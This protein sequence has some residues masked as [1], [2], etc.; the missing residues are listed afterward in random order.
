[1]LII[2]QIRYK[3]RS[4]TITRIH[5]CPTAR[6]AP[7]KESSAG[8]LQGADETRFKTRV[9]LLL[10]NDL[11]SP[12]GSALTLGAGAREGVACLA[13]ACGFPG[14]AG[15]AFRAAARATVTVAIATTIATTAVFAL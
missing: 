11:A 8:G 9:M 1:M 6:T 4:H 14:V 15:L 2:L 3:K 5:S 13:E 10:K 7:C 12:C